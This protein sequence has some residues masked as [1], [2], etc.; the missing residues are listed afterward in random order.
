MN[1]NT[2]TFHYTDTLLVYNQRL[3]IRKVEKLTCMIFQTKL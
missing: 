3:T 2:D 1:Y